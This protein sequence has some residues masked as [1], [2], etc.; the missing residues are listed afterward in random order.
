MSRLI[1]ALAL[2]TGLHGRDVTRDPELARQYDADPL[3][4]K[5]G[6]ARWYTETM[7]A[8]DRVF[9]RAKEL[10]VPMLV[11]YGGA[12]WVASADKTDAFVRSL[13]MADRTYERLAD[14]YHELVNEPQ[15]ARTKVIA[16][17]GAWLVERK[18]AR[19]A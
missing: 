18:E 2:G 9:D 1:P 10:S 16:R 17:V 7:D 11:L 6:T 8:I 13:K 15:E 14:Y 19:A 3:N 4:N 12:D 5:K